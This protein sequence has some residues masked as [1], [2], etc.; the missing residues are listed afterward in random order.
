M[1]ISLCLMARN[2]EAKLLACLQS[3]MDLVDET[4]VVDTGSTDRTRDLAAKLGA[5]VF[6]FPWCDDFAAGRNECI[7]HATGDFISGW[8]RMRGL[9]RRIG[10]T[11]CTFR[12]LPE[13]KVRN[14]KK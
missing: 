6:D 3:A 5:R 9:M 1:S 7:R 8:T 2:E 14:L 12:S 11:A 10:E 13:I 4:I